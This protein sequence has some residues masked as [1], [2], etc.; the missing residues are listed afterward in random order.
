MFFNANKTGINSRVCEMDV[1]I[2]TPTMVFFIFQKPPRRIMIL[3]KLTAL[4][5]LARFYSA[6]NCS[7]GKFRQAEITFSYFPL[8][9]RTLII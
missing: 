2:L 7:F 9:A 8:Y 1:E 4:L 6:L 5:T 3:G